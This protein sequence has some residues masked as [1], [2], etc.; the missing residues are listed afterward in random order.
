MAQKQ[1]WS[2]ISATQQCSRSTIWNKCCSGS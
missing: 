1:S 2:S